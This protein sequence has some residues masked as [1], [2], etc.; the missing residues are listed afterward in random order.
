M[1]PVV[2]GVG[3]VGINYS[4][5]ME[6]GAKKRLIGGDVE[7]EN[8]IHPFEPGEHRVIGKN[9]HV[10]VGRHSWLPN[11]GK[12]RLETIKG[13]KVSLIDRRILQKDYQRIGA[14]LFKRLEQGKKNIPAP[15]AVMLNDG[16]KQG[17]RGRPLTQG[18]RRGSI[19]HYR[20]EPDE[21]KRQG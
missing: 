12:E 21:S 3:R 9:R 17:V 6:G 8:I 20:D 16:K 11:R 18:R 13:G 14:R 10:N 2:H 1:D 15:K 4:E 7:R 5:R 19:I